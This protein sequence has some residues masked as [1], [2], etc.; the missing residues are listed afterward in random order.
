MATSGR[1]P[2]A[3]KPTVKRKSAARKNSAA[4]GLSDMDSVNDGGPA[5]ISLTDDISESKVSFSKPS[6]GSATPAA[7]GAFV[8]GVRERDLTA[9]LRQMIMLLEAGTPRLKALNSIANRGD[10]HAVRTL[11][12]DFSTQ[13]EHG[14]PLWQ[15]A[16]RPAFGRLMNVS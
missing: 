3:S 15:A 4:T 10:R 14:S 1:K 11:V 13:V 5:E 6:S 16:R 9:V 12:K 7:S 8:R 2:S